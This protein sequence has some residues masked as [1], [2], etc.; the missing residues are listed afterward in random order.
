MSSPDLPDR[1]LPERALHNPE[2][3]ARLCELGASIAR[4]ENRAPVLE[5][6]G[7]AS[8]HAALAPLS[9]G[10]AP[11]DAVLAGKSSASGAPATMLH[12]AMPVAAAIAACGLHEVR[13]AT[14]MD[15]ATAAAF[16]LALGLRAA[17][18]GSFFWISEREARAEAGS[19][20]GP[21][22]EALGLGGI[23]LVRIHAR[24]T[25]DALWAAG[26][27]AAQSGAGLCLLELRGN[28]A[29]AG[30]AFS[31]RL[32]LR[33]RQCGVPVIVLRQ[34]GTEE[35][36][37]ALTRWRVAPAPSAASMPGRKWLGPPAFAVTLEKC[38]TANG[39]Q[40]IMEWKSN[41]RLF[42]LVEPLARKHPSARLGGSRL[43]APC[44]G[45][46]ALSLALPAEAGNRPGLAVATRPGLAARRAA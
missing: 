24:R 38:R 34:G 18:P 28:P 26:E 21:G 11:L 7:P 25:A 1:T 17:A 44:G 23:D 6:A 19:F 36:S 37:A 30:L 4:I 14:S 39:G 27:I 5:N 22:L 31:R 33:A 12:T 15:A 42:A 13:A 32:A 9:L 20:Y 16:A 40:W 29:A 35:A 43:D 45:G 3:R 41:E 2:Q 8:R 46:A 10:I